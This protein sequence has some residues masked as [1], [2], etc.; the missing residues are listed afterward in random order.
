MK[1]VTLVTAL[2][3]Q[4]YAYVLTQVIQMSAIQVCQGI[5]SVMPA[6]IQ[7]SVDM[8]EETVAWTA[9]SKTI[10]R[11][12]M[13]AFAKIQLMPTL[14]YQMNPQLVVSIFLLDK[15]KSSIYLCLHH[16]CPPLSIL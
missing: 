13:I 3:V 5:D 9:C 8:M 14:I 16:F 15:K 12:A 11:I 7:R 2:L 4:A 6:P 10:V 1:T